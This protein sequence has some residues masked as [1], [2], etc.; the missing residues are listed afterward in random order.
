MIPDP[1]GNAERIGYV[2]DTR[3]ILFTRLA[4]EADPARTK[5]VLDFYSGGIELLFPGLSEEKFTYQMSD[6]LPFWIQVNTDIEGHLLDQII[7][8]S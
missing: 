6:H 2:F 5:K 8:D 3:A 7:R 1:G 4:A